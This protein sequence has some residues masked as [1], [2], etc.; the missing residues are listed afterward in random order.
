MSGILVDSSVIL[1]LVTDD[2][3]WANWSEAQL[4]RFRFRGALWINAII[5]AEVSVGFE[6]IETLENILYRGTFKLIEIPRESLFLAGK[7]FYRY[8]KKRGAKSSILPDF[9]IGSHAAV[10][11]IP[12]LTRDPKRV[13]Q[14]FPS[15]K[16]ICP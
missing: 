1:D 5:Y 9:F 10:A 3:R 4:E 15:V 12:L 14:Y 2:S 7:A 13:S 16:L 11:R 6:Q 8:R